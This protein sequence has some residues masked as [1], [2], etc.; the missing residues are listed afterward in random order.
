[1]NNLIC[2]KVI[3]CLLDSDSK[4]ADAIA[5]EIG[6]SLTTVDDQLTGLVSDS[7]CEEIRQD[8][9][10]QYVIRK[11]VEV[12]AKL[13]QEFLSN[14][15]E[16]KQEI[17]KFITSEYYLT[18]IDDELVNYVIS[19]FYLD[20]V[21]QADEDKEVL[22]KILLSSPSALF[23][24]LHE[25]TESFRES[26]AQWNRLDLSA[27]AS[28]RLIQILG[29]SFTTP[30]LERLMADVKV[31]NSLYSKLQIRVAKIGFQVGLATVDDR[32]LE[33]MGERGYTFPRVAEDLRL[34]QWVSHTDPMGISDD[35]VAFLHLGMFQTALECFNQVLDK[36]QDSSQKAIVLNNKGWAFLRFKQYQKA[37]ECFEEGIALDS[38]G[39]TPE[40][41]ENKQIAGRYLAIATDADRL[42]EPTRIRFVQNMPIPFEETIF[43]EFKEIKGGNPVE[44]IEENSD[45][46]AVAFL[47]GQGGRILWGVR[48]EDRITIGVELDERQRDEIRAKASN[49]LGAIRP[50]ISPENWQLE[51]HYVYN[52]K[53]GDMQGEIV[54]DLW[55]IELV[56]PPPQERDVF[57]TGGGSLY[58]KTDGG[59]KKLIGQEV[60]KFI[61]NLLQSEIETDI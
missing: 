61:R 47:N 20:S 13:I 7:I 48:N 50:P 35:G 2:K 4:S 40:L 22:R 39:E 24:A 30:L 26:W 31:Y 8:E 49:K 41:R 54:E 21:Y 55:V 38:D 10:C 28:N 17:V 44:R 37:I 58:V 46:Y 9:G 12:F 5:N 1:M 25:D 51:F 36:V 19:R 53:G 14:P 3:L 16:Y 60:T 27:A 57:Y 15:D 52:L 23:F 33:V 34:G 42:T 32:Y 6:E 59:K 43:Y 18:G 11:D 45:E 29:A 56:V